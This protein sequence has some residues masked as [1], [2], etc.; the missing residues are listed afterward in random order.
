MALRARGFGIFFLSGMLRVLSDEV[1]IVVAASR[2]KGRRLSPHRLNTFRRVIPSV[3]N[4]ALCCSS[5][6]A[7]LLR[8]AWT[9]YADCHAF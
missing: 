8:L 3:E 5:Y 4:V 2:H 1:K 9:D 7:M 6:S